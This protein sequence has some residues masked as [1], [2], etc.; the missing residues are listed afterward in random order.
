[1]SAREEIL[2]RVRA[3]LQ[4]H[5]VEV[6]ELPGRAATLAAPGDVDLFCERAGDYR[7][8]VV[9]ATGDDAVREAIEAAC[10]RHGVA[11]LAVAE[12]F[13]GRWR[14]RNV[15][16]DDVGADPPLDLLE[17]VDGVLTTCAA[18]I[19]QTG[20]VILD[21]GPGQGARALTLVGDLH[22]CVV[23][24]AIISDGVA[25]A[26]DEIAASVRA[27]GRPVTLISGPSATSDIE[28]DRVEGVHGPRRF[29]IV[30]AR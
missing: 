13:E 17:A 14:P 9:Q 27:A 6:D 28:L 10:T 30:V 23:P 1:M 20:T 12:G 29:E 15:T 7:A 3:A 19:A 2:G 21:G 22:I 18:A 5:P 16:I 26:V 24:G 4:A 25:A 11:R 8:N